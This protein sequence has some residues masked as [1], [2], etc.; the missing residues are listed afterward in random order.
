MNAVATFGLTLASLGALALVTQA[1][2][3]AVLKGNPTAKAVRIQGGRF[4]D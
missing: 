2:M 4:N 3:L 1:V